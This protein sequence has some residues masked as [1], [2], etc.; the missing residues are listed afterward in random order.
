MH[1]AWLLTGGA[2][3]AEI[4]AAILLRASDGFSKRIPAVAALLAF[5]T[6]FYLV[7]VALLHL[8]ISVVYPIWAGGGTAGVAIVGVLF[9]KERLHILKSTGVA[10]VVAGIVIL[11]W[12]ASTPS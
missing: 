6:A 1:Y 9:L 8:P 2:I 4:S 10:C 3:I 7:S 12:A 5:G 11:N